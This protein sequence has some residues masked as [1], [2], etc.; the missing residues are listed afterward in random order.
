M[1]MP[2][3]DL[4]ARLM[5][6]E[7]GQARTESAL[8]KLT[9]AV[10]QVARLEVALTHNGEAI[11]RAFGAIEKMGARLDKH[12]DDSDQRLK[13]LE[14]AAPISKLVNG[15]VFAWI[16]GAI[17]LIGGFAVAKLFGQ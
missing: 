7:E 3:D 12:T 14:E 16:V 5:R 1:M 9:D 6:I 13:R 10:I 4:D 17:G 2:F 8:A 11:E 15:W